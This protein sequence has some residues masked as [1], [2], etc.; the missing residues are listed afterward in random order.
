MFILPAG[1]RAALPRPAEDRGW[2]VVAPLFLRDGESAAFVLASP[3]AGRPGPSTRGRGRAEPLAPTMAFWQRW[4]CQSRYR[5][6]WREMVDRS[7]LTLKLLTYQP[8]GSIV[9]APTSA[10]P[11]RS[12]ARATGTTATPGSATSFTLYALMR[13]GYTDEAAAFMRWIEQR[14]ELEPDGSLQIMY[15]DRRP[16]RRSR[17]RPCPLRGLPGLAAGAHRQRRRQPTPTRHLRRADGLGLPVQQVRLADLLRLLEDLVRLIDWV[18]EHWDQPDE[19]I[20]EVRGGRAAVPLLAGH[21][22][23][24]DRPRPSASAS[25]RGLPAPLAALARGAGTRLPRHP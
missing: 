6:R 1:T 22:L 8:T 12:A 9:A 2:D 21:V 20:W 17:G 14:C 7:A 24:A 11:R 13:L 25:K 23:G 5:G 18:C 16:P 10:C 19:G 4:I 3:A 15:G